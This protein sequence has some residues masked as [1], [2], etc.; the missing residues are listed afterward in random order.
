MTESD[1]E[2]IDDFAER[3]AEGRELEGYKRVPGK[4]S[5]NLSVSYAI[6]LSPSE[7]EE[8]SQGAKARGMT[9]ADLMRSATR[10]ALAGEIDAEKAAAVAEVRAK[11]REIAEAASR[12]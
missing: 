6:R 11:A 7:Y 4:V 2:I 12:L 9:L 1:E 5:Q 10:A 8:F 3:I